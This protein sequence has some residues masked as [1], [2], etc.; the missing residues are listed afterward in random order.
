[1]ALGFHDDDVMTS[2]RGAVFIAAPETLVTKAQLKDFTT[3]TEIVG[4]GGTAWTNLGHLSED[5]L[6]E[7]N[8]DGGDPTVLNTWNKKGFRTKYA[9]TTG[10]VTIHSV[11]GDKDLLTLIYGGVAGSDGGVAYSIEKTPANKSVFILL[12]DT[13]TDKRGAFLLP[14]VDLTYD[15]L[16]TMNQDSFNQY[17]ILGTFKPSTSLP[18]SA[19]G[20]SN[21][22]L[23]F[24]AE[25]FASS[26]GK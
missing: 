11:Q 1:M 13:D 4:S 8:I 21:Y 22:V 3:E 19:S 24:D 5:N 18:K 6:P 26:K 25:D 7:F 2:V 16:V 15:N 17:D 20:K 10:T 9:D 12:H 23:Q 14:N